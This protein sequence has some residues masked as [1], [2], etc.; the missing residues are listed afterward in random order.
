MDGRRSKKIKK[1]KRLKRKSPLDNKSK[2]LFYYSI[3]T[4]VLSFTTRLFSFQ[5][6][7]PLVPF[8]NSIK[9]FVL[10]FTISDLISSKL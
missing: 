9:V 3:V 2:G 7:L 5:G 4:I 1:Q 6:T 8:K 10:S